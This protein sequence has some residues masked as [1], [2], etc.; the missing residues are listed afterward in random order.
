MV[1]QL[2]Y[3]HG[4]PAKAP[5]PRK[6]I[7]TQ[8]LLK[9]ENLYSPQAIYLPPGPSLLDGIHSCNLECCCGAVKHDH[10]E[11]SLAPG[12]GTQENPELENSPTPENLD[13]KPRTHPHPRR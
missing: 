9:G 11:S 12:I 3:R 6:W 5:L 10:V 1:A 2:K 7:Q 13:P 4:N 8:L